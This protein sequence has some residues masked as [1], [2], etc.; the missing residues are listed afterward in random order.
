MGVY[1]WHNNTFHYSWKAFLFAVQEGLCLLT[2]GVHPILVGGKI[3]NAI[4][5]MTLQWF[6]IAH[7]ISQVFSRFFY[8]GKHDD[9]TSFH[10]FQWNGNGFLQ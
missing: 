3:K 6:G 1:I 10:Q 2:S 9:M 5:T 7:Y 4:F 8:A